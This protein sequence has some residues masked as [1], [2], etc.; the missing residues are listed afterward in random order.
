MMI[1]YHDIA[2]EFVV[3]APKYNIDKLWSCFLY[4]II[5]ELSISPLGVREGGWA[6]QFK[7]TKTEI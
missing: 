1:L 3:K 4:E 6:S 2:M 5:L 7:I